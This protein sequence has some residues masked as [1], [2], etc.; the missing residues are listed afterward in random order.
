M[1]N[2]PIL[3][4]EGLMRVIDAISR[5]GDAPGV[6]GSV[7]RVQAIAVQEQAE[8][9]LQTACA[10]R[11]LIPFAEDPRNGNR[12]ALRSDYFEREG[13]RTFFHRYKFQIWDLDTWTAEREDYD[14]LLKTLREYNGWRI[15][16]EKPEFDVWLEAALGGP[17]LDTNAPGKALADHNI[18]AEKQKPIRKKGRRPAA[19]WPRYEKAVMEHLWEEGFPERGDGGQA[20]LEKVVSGMM[21]EDGLEASEST[22]R[23]HVRRCIDR[24]RENLQA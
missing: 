12:H 23:L 16:F 17:N 11:Q 20:A 13:S 18:E 7:E 24:Y 22:I 5:G 3:A 9:L 14:P 1:I 10:S 21:T 6:T 4:Y 2:P 15:G 8:K 19:Y